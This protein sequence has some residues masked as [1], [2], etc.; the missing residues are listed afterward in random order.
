[1]SQQQHQLIAV[2]QQQQAAA[3]ELWVR[4]V[5]PLL[6][7]QVPPT[8]PR[9][10]RPWLDEGTG[11]PL[12]AMVSTVAA[13]LRFR[14]RGLGRRVALSTVDGRGK[15]SANVTFE[16]LAARAEKV[17]S[18]LRERSSLARGDTVML[19]YRRSEVVEMMVGMMGCFLAGMAAVP[20]ATSSL[21]LEDEIT[22]MFF[23]MEN[24]RIALAMT[25][26]V[27]GKSLS[28]DFVATRG[29]V[30]RIEWWKTNEG[31]FLVKDTSGPGTGWKLPSLLGA[32]GVAQ[33]SATSTPVVLPSEEDSV[34]VGRPA[35]LAYV[36][37]TKNGAGELKGCLMDHHTLLAHCR[38]L[39]SVRAV[40]SRDVILV[41]TEPRQQFGLLVTML[42]IVAGCQVVTISDGAWEGAGWRTAVAKYGA[43]IAVVDQPGCVDIMHGA[44]ENGM[45]AGAGNGARKGSSSGSAELSSLREVWVDSCTHHAGLLED[46]EAYLKESS[47]GSA[48]I[49][50]MVSLSE[51]GGVVLATRDRDGIAED[52]GLGG[53]GERV[54]VVVSLEGLRNGRVDIVGFTG[55]GKGRASEPPGGTVSVAEA[56]YPMHGGAIGIVDPDTRALLPKCSIGEIL[57][58]SPMTLPKGFWSLPKLSEQTF[59]AHPVLYKDMGF[60]HVRRGSGIVTETISGAGFARSGL[61]G[62]IL[63]GSTVP[64]LRAPRLYVVGV[65]RDRIR[66]R[67]A[68]EEVAELAAKS[69]MDMSAWMVSKEVGFFMASDMIESVMSRIYGI[70]SWYAD[71]YASHV[72]TQLSAIFSVT[73][74]GDDLPVVLMETSRSKDEVASIAL[75]TKEIL[76]SRHSLRPYCI[77]IFTPNALPKLKPD[78]SVGTG[79]QTGFYGHTAGVVT[80]T[81]G[82]HR[83]NYNFSGGPWRKDALVRRK[84]LPVD[85]EICKSLFVSGELTPQHVIVIGRADLFS[86]IPKYDAIL[87]AAREPDIV[88][89]GRG[90]KGGSF[91][92]GQVVGGM[93][94]IPVLDDGSAIDL[95]VFPTISHV[96]RYR[97]EV[98][99]DRPVCTSID[100][101]GKETKSITFKKLSAK[102]YAIAHYLV[103]KRG[104]RQGEYLILMFPPG[105]ELLG[106][107][108]ACLY[109]GIVPIVLPPLDNSRL[110]EDI[111]ALLQI[112]TEFGVSNLFCSASVEDTLKG[113]PVQIMVKAVA[114]Q[115]TALERQQDDL[116]RPSSASLSSISS[117]DKASLSLPTVMSISKVP[118]S[119]LFMSLDDS[120]F[121]HSK[122]APLAHSAT[123]LPT[124][125]SHTP[126]VASLTTQI[127]P[128]TPPSD[129]TGSHSATLARLRKNTIQGAQRSPTAVIMVHF[130]PDMQRTVTRLS[131]ATLMEQCRLQAIHGRMLES[132]KPPRMPHQIEEGRNGALIATDRCFDGLGFV[133]SLL[134]GVYVGCVTVVVPW[135]DY[136]SNPTVWFDAVEKYQVKNAF[137]TYPM[138]EHAMSLMKD[139]RPFSLSNMGSLMLL[140]ERRTKPKAY[141]S[142]IKTYI[143]NQLEPASIGVTYSTS[144][145]PMVS[146]RSYMRSELTTLWLD[147][148]QLRRGRISVTK[149]MRGE[150]KEELEKDKSALMLQDSGKIPNNTIVAIVNP[151]TRRLCSPNEVGEVWVCSPANIDGI[152]YDDARSP[153]PHLLA[154]PNGAVSTSGSASDSPRLPTSPLAFPPTF[155]LMATVEGMD[156]NLLFAR[157]GDHGF[158]WPVPT[159]A[160]GPVGSDAAD[161]ARRRRSSGLSL[162]DDNPVAGGLLRNV[163]L[164]QQGQQP[165]QGGAWDRLVLAGQPCEM[166]LFVVGGMEEVLMVN[167]LRHYPGDIEKTVAGCHKG[168]VEE[169]CVVFK[170]K[171]TV[172]AVVEIAGEQGATALSPRILAAVLEEHQFLLDVVCYVRAGHLARSRVGE[173]QRIRVKLAYELRKL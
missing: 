20:V 32:V 69:P 81:T 120:I 7:R 39:I 113:R 136:V 4:N 106:A 146:S 42:A 143:M 59:R 155:D 77:M 115:Q 33:Q 163:H 127:P 27:T 35:E 67:K 60:G 96:L 100:Y 18:L 109:A 161:R 19:V 154:P 12:D 104:I 159:T 49:V 107:L 148:R 45:I 74:S 26:D 93:M 151:E 29:G 97:A 130:N 23:M 173:K 91:K 44:R 50:P 116:V 150:F 169:G 95:S 89:S 31:A 36:E 102:V 76:Q 105:S 80:T 137:A 75:E 133:C 131:H 52:I 53:S 40:T 103:E 126:P 149:E 16:R 141:R 119:T 110:K 22:E 3:D 37:Y 87:D 170:S 112:A 132:T 172:V 124:P 101:R 21:A 34:G 122:T 17:A 51:M 111:P 125:T 28:K 10:A 46:L 13:A 9:P 123:S 153:N 41:Q 99:P 5:L 145:N 57:L 166:V 165:T 68:A 11:T 138:M 94:D 73:I 140:T 139:L 38:C 144:V 129:A 88:V 168:I 63:D 82:P 6:H 134:L 70:E 55:D 2:Q 156:P 167:G 24:C 142:L 114:Q 158:L 117:T 86:S 92:V 128:V 152:E 61:F 90:A 157:T 118:K 85:V 15:E 72:N 84:L 98:N 162:T 14:G 65:G 43:T 171:G 1:M 160:D 25:T 121:V 47:A 78:P 30:P 48:V 66:Q 8:R 56:G 108:H 62:F 164:A 147:L 83:V 64:A 54:D 71:F 58:Q 135:V 79:M